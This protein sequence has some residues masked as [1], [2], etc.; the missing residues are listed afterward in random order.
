MSAQDTWDHRFGQGEG[1]NQLFKIDII[2]GAPHPSRPV[3]VSS[4]SQRCLSSGEIAYLRRDKA[5]HGVFLF[6][7]Q[8]RPKGSDLRCPSW[9]P[10]A[11]SRIQPLRI[12][13]SRGAGEGMEPE[14][15]V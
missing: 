7:R 4:Y 1:D 6:E 13:A 14:S 3:P 2:S 11:R 9:S 12:Q 15:E 8:L 10:T 5:E